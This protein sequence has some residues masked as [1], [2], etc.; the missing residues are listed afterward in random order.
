MFL[1]QD[2]LILTIA[3]VRLSTK[4]LNFILKYHIADI[5]IEIELQHKHRHK[6]KLKIEIK[7]YSIQ[8]KLSLITVLYSV[9]LH[10][11]N[12][13][14]KSRSIA[15]SHKHKKKMLNLKHKQQNSYNSNIGY[16]QEEVVHN[17]SLYVLS[18]EKHEALSYGLDNHIPF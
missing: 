1:K 14:I 2:Q 13:A 10:K 6:K 17:F 3:N 12:I 9:L 7:N 8:L 16:T 4:G 11:I 18:Q 15:I 5:A